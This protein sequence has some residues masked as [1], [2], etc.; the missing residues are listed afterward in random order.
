MLYRPLLLLQVIL[1]L[2]TLSL[3]APRWY[4]KYRVPRVVVPQSYYEV[5][6]TP[7]NP[8]AVADITCLDPRAYAF[9]PTFSPQGL[10]D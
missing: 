4:E 2:S 1:T 7:A 8:R 10:I 9:P 3:A 5:L 6:K